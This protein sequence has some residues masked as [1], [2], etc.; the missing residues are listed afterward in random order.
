MAHR[1]GAEAYDH[2]SVLRLPHYGDAIC[3]GAAD[4]SLWGLPVSQKVEF[5]ASVL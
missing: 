1:S 4:F 2:D 5:H 3:K